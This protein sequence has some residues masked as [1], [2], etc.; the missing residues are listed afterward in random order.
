MFSTLPIYLIIY[1]ILIYEL[2]STHSN[3]VEINSV[4]YKLQKKLTIIRKKFE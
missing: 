2:K 1:N 4:K 3:L